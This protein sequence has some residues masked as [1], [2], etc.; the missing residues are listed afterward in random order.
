MSDS[1]NLTLSVMNSSKTERYSWAAYTICV[2]LSSL[3]GD[4]LILIASFH[5]AIKVH[6]SIL[7]IIRHMAI[8]DLAFT[9]SVVFPVVT[10][11]IANTWV[12]GE[13]LCH[14]RVYIGYFIHS[15]CVCFVPFL[16]TFKLVILKTSRRSTVLSKKTVHLACLLV[17]CSS[18]TFPLTFLAFGKDDIYFNPKTYLCDL[19]F[20][21]SIWKTLLPIISVLYGLV[22]N[23]VIIATTI[24]TLKY[25]LAARKSAQ[26]VGGSVP[27]HGALTVVVTAMV[28]LVSNLPMSIYYL[29]SSFVDP[30]NRFFFSLGRVSY[31]MS[32]INIASNFYIY[33]FTVPSFRRFIFSKFLPFFRTISQQ[34]TLEMT[35]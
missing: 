33:C 11:L 12:L 19:K 17:W 18:A 7:V 10:S 6:T 2:L 3:I 5:G 28:F 9:V 15:A 35:L 22:P 25:L 27:W 26:R 8:S 32:M 30:N 21:A 13:T 1:G 31:F 24:P 34:E 16:A 20:S 23:I 4:T 29:C 14:V